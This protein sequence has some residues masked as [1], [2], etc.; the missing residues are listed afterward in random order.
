MPYTDINHGDIVMCISGDDNRWIGLV[1][2]RYMDGDVVIR[3]FNQRTRKWHETDKFRPAENDQ[4][5]FIVGPLP[6]SAEWDVTV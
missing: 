3:W 5:F 4:T 2:R 1:T 6:A